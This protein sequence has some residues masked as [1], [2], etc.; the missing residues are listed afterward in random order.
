MS[1]YQGTCGGCDASAGTVCWGSPVLPSSEGTLTSTQRLA[2]KADAA[3]YGH[4][5]A[6]RIASGRAAYQFASATDYLRYKKARVLANPATNDPF[7]GPPS[8][9]IAA[10]QR[11][12]C[13][14]V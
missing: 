4:V 5:N 12:G 6:A 14:T 7:R 9:A 3:L 11:T 10:I 8:A 1:T 13:P 2:G